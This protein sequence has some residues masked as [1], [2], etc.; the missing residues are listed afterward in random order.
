MLAAAFMTI[1]VS[2]SAY[3]TSIVI[4]LAG[5]VCLV[6][7]SLILRLLANGYTTVVRGV[8]DLLIVYL[9]YF[10]SSQALSG[11]FGDNGFIAPPTFLTGFLAVG[12][13]AGAYQAQVFRG[14]LDAVAKGQIEAASAYGMPRLLAFR[15]IVLPQAI[16]FALPGAANV[17]QVVLKDSALISVVGLVE[18]MRQA[19]IGAGSTRQPFSFFL[20]AGVLYLAIT[21]ISGTAFRAI[22]FR[23][24]RGVRRAA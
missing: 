18:L 5:A 23:A 6:S 7:H 15:R 8:P 21:F 20:T 10:G 22:E 19:Q 9:F 1:A 2:A 11:L 16:R 14:A 24:Q 17:W 3:L 4:G 13:V 12:V